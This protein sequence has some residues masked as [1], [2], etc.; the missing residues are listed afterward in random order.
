MRRLVKNKEIFTV[1]EEYQQ[2]IAY[3]KRVCDQL[4]QAQA[5]VA[6]K[7]GSSEKR[8]GQAE[9]QQQQQQQRQL[10][11]LQDEYSN[12]NQQISH[13]EGE[14]K[15]VETYELGLIQNQQQMESKLRET[16]KQYSYYQNEIEMLGLQKSNLQNAY[17][18]LLKDYRRV[19]KENLKNEPHQ[20]HSSQDYRSKF[21][22]QLHSAQGSGDLLPLR[23][24]P[25]DPRS[26]EPKHAHNKNLSIYNIE[27]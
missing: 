16:A 24:P 23:Q 25:N 18:A 1:V 22:T 6:G 14:I 19:T 27:Q 4:Q 7:S 26:R 11:E 9:A 5:R 15:R 2:L 13:L 12:L 17:D 8:V 3:R 20:Y 10:A 21:A